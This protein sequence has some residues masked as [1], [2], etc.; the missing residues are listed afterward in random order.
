MSSTSY[1]N[2]SH[3]HRLTLPNLLS[4]A[5]LPAV[6]LL[7]VLA[8]YGFTGWFMIILGFVF[9]TDA[10]DGYLARRW[11]QES[12]LGARLDSV[13][14]C[15]VYL[16]LPICLWWLWPE[17]MRAEWLS[18]VVG[19]VAYLL[20]LAIGYGRFK[21]LTAYHTRSGKAAA[22]ATALTLVVIMAGGPGW[23]IRLAVVLIVI[24]GIENIA[25]T[26]SLAEW[27]PDIASLRAARR[28]RKRRH[29]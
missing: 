22:I 20:P 3:P 19:I 29:G 16:A 4:A 15:A 11:H 8:F 26:C 1:A 6:L 10:V 18:I 12:A 9:A 14:D 25:I 28:H 17:F 27:S 21:R 13:G 24:A 2:G 23:P 7:L 5:R